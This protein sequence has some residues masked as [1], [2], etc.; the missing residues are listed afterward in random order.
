MTVVP[1]QPPRLVPFTLD[2]EETRV[3]EGS[4]ILDACRA[5]GKDIPT[6]C[7]GD[8]LTPKNACRVCVVEVEGS[9]TLAAKPAPVAPSR[10]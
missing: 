5:A 2:G 6:L 8:T 1:L 3:P 7:Q 4:T 10:A 9:R